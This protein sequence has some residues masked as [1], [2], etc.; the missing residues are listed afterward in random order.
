MALDIYNHH[1]DD[2]GYSISAVIGVWKMTILLTIIWGVVT[3]FILLINAHLDD[4][5]LSDREFARLVL[6]FDVML[7]PLGVI[8]II[9]EAF[10]CFHR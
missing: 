2:Y 8:I 7:M 1:R 6:I 5:E 4:G 3:G 9:G 10:E